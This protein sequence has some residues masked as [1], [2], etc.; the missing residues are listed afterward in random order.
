MGYETKMYIGQVSSTGQETVRTV[1]CKE[2]YGDGFEKGIE[3]VYGGPVENYDDYIW[4]EDRFGEEIKVPKDNFE[5]LESEA[6]Y[7][8]V[9]AMIDL[10]KCGGGSVMSKLIKDVHINE[11]LPVV[12]FYGPDGNLPI[13]EDKYGDVL[14]AVP[15]VDVLDALKESNETTKEENEG[16]PYRRF[17]LAISAL[18]E[19][20]TWNEAARG[21]IKVI[22]YGY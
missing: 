7:F 19:I 9:I 11:H 2:L 12:Y 17:D 15:V 6:T 10:C 16:Q 22:L 1:I 14:K 5:V 13:K 20:M 3:Y 8:S 18:T 4:T 21:I